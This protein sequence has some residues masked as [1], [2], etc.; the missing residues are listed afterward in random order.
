MKKTILTICV[1]LSL[2]LTGT[3]IVHAQGNFTIYPTY[4][5]NGNKGW[6]ISSIA[7]GNT[8]SD[9]VTLQNLTDQPQSITL[10]IKEATI[11]NDKFTA[12]ESTNFKDLGNWLQLPQTE[13]TLAPHEQIKV[14]V[15]I[16]IPEN[17]NQK[18]YTGAIYAIQQKTNSQNV[19]IITRVG[20]RLYI[21]V[22]APN[23][24]AANILAAPS[25]KNAFY[26]FFSLVGLLAATLYNLIH[27]LEN[28]KHAKKHA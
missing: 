24:F 14:P 11:Q 13:F 2:V 7:T 15:M 19:K 8:A 12:I 23:P 10:A 26:F 17:T 22:T 4:E 6:I 1:S 21:T 18:E 20:V 3:A 27:I 16:S 5:H 9:S 25:F 28:K